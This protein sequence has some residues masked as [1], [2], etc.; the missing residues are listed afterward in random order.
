M[1]ICIGLR[2][3]DGIVIASDAQES[4]GDLKRSTQKIFT[5]M[6]PISPG[7]N[8][9]PP[10][11]ACA[12]TGAGDAGYLDAF[13]ADVLYNIDT[14]TTRKDF[15]K[16]L[17]D[18]ILTFHR[19]HIFPLAAAQYPPEIDVLIGVYV[20]LAAHIFVSRGSALSQLFPDVAVGIGAHF[21]M[22]LID[23][24]SGC[25]NLKETELLAAYIVSRTKESIEGCGKYTQIV[26]LHNAI[27]EEGESGSRLVP[28]LVPLT[29]VSDEQIQK[30][31]RSFDRRWAAHSRRLI[32][33][34]IQEE[35]D[36]DA[37]Q[38]ASQTSGPVP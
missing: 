33:D 24:L 34:L 13:F 11:F 20:E 10:S 3:S 36:D 37:K 9:S 27:V 14:K 15:K 30:W 5:F 2:A 38:L 32:E 21:A 18:K 8:P 6:G 17:A 29:F 23:D 25:R 35:L 28:P 31:E 26:S 19:Q 1:T 22:G 16:F 7:S 4:K 12:L